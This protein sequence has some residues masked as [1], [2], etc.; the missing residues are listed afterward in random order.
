MS[1]KCRNTIFDA[2][3]LYMDPCN[4]SFLVVQPVIFQGKNF[5]FGH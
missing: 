2:Y 1:L 4:Q 5:N 3:E